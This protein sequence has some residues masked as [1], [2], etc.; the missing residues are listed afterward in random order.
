M[1]HADANSVRIIKEA[2]TIFSSFI[3][4]GIN[5]GKN[6]AFY[7]GVK[8][9]T[10]FSIF[11]I[12][13]IEE[14]SL[15][16]RYLGR[17]EL[18]V[19]GKRSN[20]RTHA[21]PKT[22]EKS[23][24]RI[25]SPRTKL[26]PIGLLGV[27]KEIGFTLDQMGTLEFENTPILHN[28]IISI[29]QIRK[30]C[31]LATV[32]QVKSGDW[33]SLLRI[34]PKGVRIFDALSSYHLNNHEDFH[35]WSVENNGRFNLRSTWDCVRDH[36][37]VVPW[38][39]LVWSTKVIPKHQFILWLAFRERLNTHDRIKKYMRI[40]DPN[41]LLFLVNEESIEHLLGNCPFASLFWRRFSASMS[42]PSFP[43]EWTDI[44]DLAI[45]KTKSNDFSSN[46]FKCFFANIVYHI[47]IERNARAFLGVRNNADIV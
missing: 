42:L 33:N 43:N 7:G 37:D 4:L 14:G 8:E 22:K 3:G 18:G 17:I 11:G 36:G 27:G 41:C 35:V 34:I 29:T 19:V 9:E 1:A 30:E 12:M 28:N 16:V 44:K 23:A 5:Q 40:P 10:K 32:Q 21:S 25:V 15:H 26:S 38:S 13:G 6:L 24:S 46:T 39:H 45:I 20:G 2:L 47:C 31:L